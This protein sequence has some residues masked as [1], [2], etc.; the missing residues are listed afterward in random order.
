MNKKCHLDLCFKIIYRLKIPSYP[1]HLHIFQN[2]IHPNAS[3]M[4]GNSNIYFFARENTSKSLDI[5]FKN[6]FQPLSSIPFLFFQTKSK[7]KEETI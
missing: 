2:K 7:N 4:L 1:K 3:W 6:D 5:V